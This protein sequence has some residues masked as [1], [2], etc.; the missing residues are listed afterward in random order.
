MS[1][2]TSTSADFGCFANVAK[3]QSLY[4]AQRSRTQW[5]NPAAFATPRVATTVGQTD[6]SVLG[7]GP[8]QA[9][10]PNYANLDASLFKNFT[11]T[12]TWRAQLRIEAFNAL[13]MTEFGQP[14]S[15]NYTTP[16]NFSTIT[17]LRGSPRISPIVGKI[18]F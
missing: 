7:G 11:F 5:L 15:L 14:G 3:A 4:A 13:N 10:G 2:A 17:G 1:C 16:T 6:Y 9:R 12:E 8:D 18:F